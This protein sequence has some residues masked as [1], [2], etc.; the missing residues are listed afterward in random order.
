MSGSTFAAMGLGIA[1]PGGGRDIRVHA[2]K[3][4]P[5]GG[6]L[7]ACSSAVQLKACSSV[8]VQLKACS[9]AVQLK[10]SW[11]MQFS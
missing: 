4:P 11:G 10:F 3:I 8:S 7:T 5:N 1:G 9:S 6:E 2:C